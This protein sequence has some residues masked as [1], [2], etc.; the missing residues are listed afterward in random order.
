MEND[1]AKKK[2]TLWIILGVAG[3]VLLLGCVACGGVGVFLFVKGPSKVQEAVRENDLKLIGVAYL[4][5]IDVKKQAPSDRLDLKPFLL[6][7]K[8]DKRIFDGEITVLWNTARPQEQP[9]GA[10]NVVLAWETGVNANTTR[11]VLFM[12]GRVQAMT[13][14]EFQQA[15][16]A[17]LRL[18]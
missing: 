9:K 12:D 17:R 5:H 16:K 11:Q 3:G 18:R 15:P 6:S 10:G 7:I 14:A 13:D 1:M 2:T 4:T 8:A